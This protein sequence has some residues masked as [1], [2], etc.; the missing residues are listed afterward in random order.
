MAGDVLFAGGVE[1]GNGLR[2]RRP[3][4]F[5]GVNYDRA[6]A[7]SESCLEAFNAVLNHCS[8]QNQGSLFRA[9]RCRTELP[10]DCFSRHLDKSGQAR[11]LRGRWAIQRNI[12]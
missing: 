10:L 9:H 5:K 6:H 4:G 7:E 1:E 8:T 2:A 12:R 3:G 11:G